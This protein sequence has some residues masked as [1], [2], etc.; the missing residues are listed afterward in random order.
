MNQ[1]QIGIIGCGNISP[2]YLNAVKTFPH[3]AVRACADLNP[4]AAA[5]CAEAH[6]LEARDV[7]TLLASSDIDIILNLTTPQAHTEVNCASL[8]AGKHVYCEKPL[9]LT[10][11]DGRR[12]CDLAA[13][14]GLRV[15]CAPDTFLGG[16]HQTA[17]KLIDDGAIGTPIA[18]TAFMMCHGHEGWHPNPVFYYQKGGGPLFDMGPY[19]LTALIALL[20]PVRSVAAYTS[21][22]FAERVATSKERNGERIPVEVPTHIAGTLEFCNGAI[23]TMVTSFDV[24]QH[25]HHFIEIYGTE[26]SLKIPDPNCFDGPVSIYERE[27]DAWKDVPLTHGYTSNM[28]SIGVADMAAAITEGRAHRCAGE[29]AYHVLDVMHA[30]HESAELR[31]HIDICSTC[32]KPAPLPTGLKEGDL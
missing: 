19:Y 11:E 20:G 8:E 1:T 14:K 12:T 13:E 31:K 16:G 6:G 23:I 22:T 18:G 9:A 15:G 21:M 2:A 27:A 29:M 17:R 25:T 24:W 7:A 10:R 4:S 5:A 3:V 28:R 26:S 32:E 30:F